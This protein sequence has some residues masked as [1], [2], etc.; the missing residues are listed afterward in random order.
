MLHGTVSSPAG[1]FTNL[2]ATIRASDR[3]V[4]AVLYGG[5]VG[6]GGV[7]P[8]RASA[9]QVAGFA[10]QVLQV[11]GADQLDVVGYSQGGL[12]LRT[13]LD[14]D[15]DPSLVATAV[16]IA[17][18]YHGTRS[19]LTTAIPAG[20]C[21]ACADQKAGSALL[22]AL[23]RDGD[24]AGEVRYAVISSAR[25]TVVTPVAS[26]VPDGPPDRVRSIIVE[27]SCPGVVTDH[28]DLPA[29]PQVGRWVVAALE[30]DGR[31]AAAD[32]GC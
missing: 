31:P 20:L 4:Y 29:E 17:P 8:V 14:G 32:L 18:S 24:L 19:R 25:D 13:M 30:T 1:N 2:A 28:V 26:Q 23:D 7:G 27:D 16:L 9:R 6:L 12:V 15:L 21:P 5:A 3:C 10:R 22:V 11:T